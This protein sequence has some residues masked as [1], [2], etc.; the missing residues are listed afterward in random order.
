MAGDG[1]DCA[2][3]D[4]RGHNEEGLAEMRKGM[5]A[6]RAT[7]AGLAHTYIL[8]L[9]AEAC[10]RTGRS[11]EGLAMLDEAL[12]T[13]DQRG[14]R[15]FEAE[16]HRL[17]GELTLQIAGDRSIAEVARTGSA[18]SDEDAPPPGSAL[19]EA[20]GSLVR[21][22]DIAR[23]Q[24]AKAFELRA[25]MSLCRLWRAQGRREDARRLL[26]EVYGPFVEGLDTRDLK[27]ARRM[28]DD[29]G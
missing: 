8:S 19:D 1:H 5:E 26:A 2:R 20:E 7:G 27:D 16:L 17:K 9:L 29:L 24:G 6:Y 15:V 13:L 18:V 11:D 3:A 14:E 21:A 10:A 12:Q 25:A 22:L 28:L 23:S 4:P